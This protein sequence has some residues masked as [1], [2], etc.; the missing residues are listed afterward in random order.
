MLVLV[1]AIKF[2]P[3]IW[4]IEK[5]HFSFQLHEKKTVRHGQMTVKSSVGSHEVNTRNKNSA[6]FCCSNLFCFFCSGTTKLKLFHAKKSVN[7]KI[8]SI[9]CCALRA[10]GVV[11]VKLYSIYVQIWSALFTIILSCVFV[12]KS[13]CLK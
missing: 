1:K 6:R 8:I 13:K 2:L 11:L 9:T 12:S 3:E 10:L 7:I 4:I 5:K